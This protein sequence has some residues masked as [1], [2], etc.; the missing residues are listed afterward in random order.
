MNNQRKE[1]EERLRQA[2]LSE[3]E[4]KDYRSLNLE[5]LRL[6]FVCNYAK[7]DE[8]AQKIK[9]MV[10]I[11]IKDRIVVYTMLGDTTKRALITG[12]PVNENYLACLYAAT[13]KIEP[14]R[15]KLY[16]LAVFTCYFPS[17]N[18]GSPRLS[19]ESVLQQVPEKVPV[20]QACCFE[21]CFAS[22]DPEKHYD[23]ILQC[24]KAT[25]ILWTSMAEHE[26]ALDQVREKI[27]AQSEATSPKVETKSAQEKTAP[28]RFI[29]IRRRS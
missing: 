11:S 3:E 4:K 18:A 1:F 28:C 21:V 10:R 12:A 22:G 20:K 16:K 19:M 29:P 26:R 15:C 13:V 25:V 2:G 23:K 27:S 24:H 6:R 14:V 5:L 7:L 17:K 9:P 8:L